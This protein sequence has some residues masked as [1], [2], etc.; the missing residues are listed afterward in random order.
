MNEMSEEERL[1][2][3][4]KDAG[5]DETTIQKFIQLHK[6][7]RQQEKY[8]LLAKHRASLLEQVHVRQQMVDCLDY[9]VYTM[10]KEY[11]QRQESIEQ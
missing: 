1:L 7:G 2:R 8:R 6:E 10:K 3:N 9:L 5:C 4:L 11:L